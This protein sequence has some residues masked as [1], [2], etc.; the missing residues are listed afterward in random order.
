V[1]GLDG[2][3]AV[4][5]VLHDEGDGDRAVTAASYQFRLAT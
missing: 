2:L 3:S 5:V 1:S 4:R